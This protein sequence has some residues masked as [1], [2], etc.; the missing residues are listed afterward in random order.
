[1]SLFL[2]KTVRKT[3]FPAAKPEPELVT[4][5][6]ASI[7]GIDESVPVRSIRFIEKVS[8]HGYLIHRTDG[9]VT[10]I[11]SISFAELAA[12]IAAQ[13]VHLLQPVSRGI[14][15]NVSCISRISRL[16]NGRIEIY[17]VNLPERP[18]IAGEKYAAFFSET[19]LR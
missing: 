11:N 8:R 5:P 9:L 10:L 13:R 19:F 16:E 18:F 17:L 3:L 7:H 14:I 12:E 2:L 1:M 15:L 6:A 4:F